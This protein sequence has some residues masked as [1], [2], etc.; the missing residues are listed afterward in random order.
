M[1]YQAHAD[2][3]RDIAADIATGNL[4][5]PTQLCI[6]FNV[7]VAY[8]KIQKWLYKCE[9]LLRHICTWRI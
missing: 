1:Q 5:C 7:F 9:K 4:T 8:L 3:N 2:V 6:K